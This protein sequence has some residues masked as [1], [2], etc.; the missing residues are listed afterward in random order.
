MARENITS[1]KLSYVGTADPAAYGINYEP[2]PGCLYLE[3]QSESVPESFVNAPAGVY[4]IS[5][6]NLQGL[7]FKNH[8][9]YANFRKRKPDAMIGYSIFIYRIPQTEDQSSFR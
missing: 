9:L 7:W 4:A 6:S 2:L 1:V 5:V 3:R 8:D